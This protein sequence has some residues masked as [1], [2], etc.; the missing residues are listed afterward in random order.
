MSADEN[1]QSPPGPGEPDKKIGPSP[2]AKPAPPTGEGEPSSAKAVP[3]SASREV[4]EDAP[5]PTP[6]SVPAGGEA[7]LKPAAA[8]AGDGAAPAPQ[9]APAAPVGGESPPKPEPKPA[10]VVA[11]EGAA[12]APKPAAPK[13]PT[14]P[15]PVELAQRAPVPSALLDRL[16][17]RFPEIA[18]KATF[19]S[20]VPIVPVP[21]EA[22][23][24]VCR[25]LKEDTEADCKYLSNI[26][27]TH[28]PGGPKPFE[29]VYNAF[30]ISR[31]QWIMLKVDLADNEEIPTVTSVWRTANWHER[32]AFD[33]VG[34]RFTGHPDMT[35][36]LLPD[37]WVGH[38]LRKDY[39]LE[40]KEGDHKSYR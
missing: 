24:E 28:N 23:V 10:T 31:A 14:G 30:S 40:G 36:I 34:I 3:Q 11:A 5:A 18:S 32:E 25:F 37:D 21:V 33:L 6:T 2:D 22:I 39:P 8:A 20:G 38:P 26:H 27:G 16:H 4:G 13:P 35:R 1:G 19:F 15:S 17:S 9:P 12:P 29:V 7:P